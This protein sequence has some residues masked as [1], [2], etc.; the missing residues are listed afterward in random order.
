MAIRSDR[1][2]AVVW[3]CFLLSGFAALL[4]QTVWTREF[5]F[6]FGTSDLAV[7]T[8]LAAYMAGLAIGAAAAARLV[9]RVRRP[10]LAYAVLE[11]GIA[12]CAL[13]VPLV[14]ATLLRVSSA[15]FGGRTTL[16]AESET[17]LAAFWLLSAFAILI[18]PTA[19]MGATLPLL[20]R[21][22]VQREEEIGT[23]IGALYAVNTLGAVLGTITAAFLLLPALGLRGTV[24]VGVAAN[25]A[26][27]ALAATLGRDRARENEAARSE[28]RAATGSRVHAPA[29]DGAALAGIRGPSLVLPLILV[30]GA[31]SFTY[32]VLWTRQIGRA[33][34]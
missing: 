17:L 33:H 2:L 27:F 1:S 23:K 8:V 32:E 25:A 31:A 24:W 20:A 14:I 12:L 30:S 11:L 13:A 4:Y 9:A 34:V 21:H 26:V 5:A 15:V 16:P 6:V 3:L 18:V 19:L 10:V 29:T 22:V 7:A 28:A